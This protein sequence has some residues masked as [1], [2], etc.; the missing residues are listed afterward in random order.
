[1]VED[2]LQFTF[3]QGG[4]SMTVGA[5]D[6]GIIDYSG[7]EGADYKISSAERIRGV[8]SRYT[9]TR[10][11][12]RDITVTAEYKKRA[13]KSEMRLFLVSF[14]RPDEEGVLTVESAGTKR[15]IPYRVE[16]FAYKQTNI[17][18]K[19]Q[20]LAEL[21]CLDPFFQ[22]ITRTGV[23]IMTLVGGWKWPFTLPF[24]MRQYGELK[25]NILNSGDVEAPVEIFF[26]GP[27]VRPKII[28]HRSGEYIQITR[29]L[30]ASETLYINT[31]ESV[32]VIEIRTEDSTEDGW[33]YVD[34]ASVFWRLKPG[35][36]M[37][38]YSAGA[39]RSKGVE[40]FYRARYLGI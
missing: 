24:K 33:A 18:E 28:N 2:R 16:G 29:N 20:F 39:L 22:S 15:Q 38:E 30:T 8:G 31:G 23:S 21:T 26:Q 25:K 40:V 32:P 10:I 36:N 13:R 37:I 34:P 5:N 3:E 35:D 11:P 7:I 12:Q 19:L 4:R 27:A 1:M 6:F 17:H 14:F 9:K